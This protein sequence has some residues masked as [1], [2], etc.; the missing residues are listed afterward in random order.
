MLEVMEVHYLRGTKFQLINAGYSRTAFHVSSPADFNT[1]LI[2]SK[3]HQTEKK[4]P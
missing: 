2:I 3:F 4:Q 1:N